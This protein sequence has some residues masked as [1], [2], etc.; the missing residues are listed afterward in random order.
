M[1]KLYKACRRASV[2]RHVGG[3]RLFSIGWSGCDG[4]D[5]LIVGRVGMV[6]VLGIIGLAMLFRLVD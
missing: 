1:I 2:A 6:V 5:S 3:Y 4:C